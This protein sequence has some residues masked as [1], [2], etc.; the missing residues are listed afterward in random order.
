MQVVPN[1][2]VELHLETNDGIQIYRTRV[3]DIYDDL[4][5][6]G[7]PMQQGHL[8]PIRIGTK[9][10]VQ[11]KLQSSLQEGRFKNDAIVE[12]RSSTHVPYLQLRLLGNWEKTQ[13]RA[14]VRV[15][16]FIEALFIVLDSN[17]EEIPQTGVILNLSGGGFMLRTSHPFE[18]DD[19]VRISFDL[20][21]QQIVTVAQVARHIPY[22]GGVDYGF[23]FLD[24]PEPVRKGIIKF[25]YK[26]QI[27]L[28]EVARES[29]A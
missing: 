12:K 3:E 9:L 10:S 4:I 27:D 13:E 15:P 1:Q 11:F 28:A 7:A 6:V 21:R 25:V 14:F 20:A 5:V 22:E 26:R 16:V 29:Q 24:L 23:T 17:K 8:V 19:Q 18:I 2:L